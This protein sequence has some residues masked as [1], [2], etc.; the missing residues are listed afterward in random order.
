MKVILSSLI[1]FLWIIEKFSFFFFFFFFLR[2]YVFERVIHDHKALFFWLI[3]QQ[4]RLSMRELII[5]HSV[6]RTTRYAVRT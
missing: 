3:Q 5:L 2:G 6:K 1:F 4:F